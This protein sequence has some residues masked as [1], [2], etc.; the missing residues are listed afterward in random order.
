M[1]IKP[2][3]GTSLVDEWLRL[4]AS[5]AEGLGLIPSQGTKISHAMWGTPPPKKKQVVH[6][7]VPPA[8][9]RGWVPLLQRGPKGCPLPE[10]QAPTT[11]TWAA[12]CPP[13]GNGSSRPRP[14]ED[15]ASTRSPASS[16]PS[17]GWWPRP[18]LT[19]MLLPPRAEGS[20]EKVTK[21]P[22][23]NTTFWMHI[24]NSNWMAQIQVR[25]KASFLC[26]PAV[27]RFT[28]V[29]G[30]TRLSF[31]S[32]HWVRIRLWISKIAHMLVQPPK[33]TQAKGTQAFPV[34]CCYCAPSL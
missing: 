8:W 4:C 17:S 18:T 15:T 23:P 32:I 34:L 21:N 27:N 2:I 28:Q 19:E 12:A 5:T 24:R 22:P 14:S 29:R 30:R 9:G 26:F 16:G 33:E 6:I 1:L 31:R 3:C 10:T 11:G 13:A 20:G 25:A 7:P